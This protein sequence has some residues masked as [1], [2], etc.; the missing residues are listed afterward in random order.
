[1]KQIHHGLLR[2]L[3]KYLVAE[4]KTMQTDIS[5]ELEMLKQSRQK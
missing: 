4:T 2:L 3:H 1:M 5:K